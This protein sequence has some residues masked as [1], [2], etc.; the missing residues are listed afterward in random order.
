MTD[1]KIEGQV[2]FKSLEKKKLLT[3]LFSVKFLMFPAQSF[4]MANWF[5]CMPACM[6]VI[7]QVSFTTLQRFWKSTIIFFKKT[8]YE[9]LSSV[10]SYAFIIPVWKVS[11]RHLQ[12][13]DRRSWYVLPHER[14]FDIS[15]YRFFFELI[16]LSGDLKTINCRLVNHSM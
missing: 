4:V 13:D 8:P 12:Q 9:V 11:S 3:A 1:T 15:K 10:R 6:S 14:D 16:Y 7:G 5:V 2:S